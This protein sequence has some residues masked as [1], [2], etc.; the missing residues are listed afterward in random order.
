MSSYEDEY[1]FPD[2][3]V[4]RNYLNIRDPERLAEAEASIVVRAMRNGLREP[5]DFTPDG[6]RNVHRQMFEKLY[7]FAGEFRRVDM[8]KIG[9]DGKTR[10]E[11]MKGAYVER[12][13]LEKSFFRD[14]AA[15][16]PSER[17]FLKPSLPEFAHRAS[18]YL[19]EL[20]FIHPFPEGNGRVQRIF[21]QELAKRAGYEID[22]TKIDR[23]SWIA[24]SVQ[25]R[26]IP[27][28]VD[29]KFSEHP[30]MSQLIRAACRD[31]GQTR[32]V[33][34]RLRDRLLDARAQGGD[35]TRDRDDGQER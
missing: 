7:P 29:G 18:V 32:D 34:E 14:L 35:Q 15:D 17:G 9:E 8:A 2:T 22:L 11:F 16:L 3:G 21:L 20:N 30:K 5:F 1:C 26:E 13:G 6:L 4:L 33:T 31:R 25:S 23:A 19:K 24:A 27:E 10:I 12:I 28:M